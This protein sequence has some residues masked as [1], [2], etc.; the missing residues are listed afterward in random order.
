MAGWKRTAPRRP[1]SPEFRRLRLVVLEEEPVCRI[2]GHAPSNTVDHIQP[3]ARGGSDARGNLR[4]VCG[5]CNLRK[6]G[7][8]DS[9]PLATR[10]RPPERHPG[11]VGGKE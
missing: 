9:K 1:P 8:S 5:P 7:A 11:M 2:C 6:A 4:G 3:V 10:M